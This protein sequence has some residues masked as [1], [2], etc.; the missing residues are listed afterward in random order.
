MP[1]EA[2]DIPTIWVSSR[3][4]DL[5][6]DQMR[7]VTCPGSPAAWRTDVL[8]ALPAMALRSH[9]PLC[10]GSLPPG[11]VVDAPLLSSSRAN[12]VPSPEPGHWR[13]ASR[14]RPATPGPDPGKDSPRRRATLHSTACVHSIQIPRAAFTRS[15]SAEIPPDLPSPSRQMRR[16]RENP[17]RRS[18]PFP[19]LPEKTVSRP[20]GFAPAPPYEVVAGFIRCGEWREFDA[21]RARHRLQSIAPALSRAVEAGICKCILGTHTEISRLDWPFS[22]GV[23]AFPRCRVS[24]VSSQCRSLCC[25]RLPPRHCCRLYTL[26]NMLP[27][28]H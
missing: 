27:P 1:L 18:Y 3:Q 13:P 11:P 25:G 22:I 19:P 20:K 15:Q 8:R 2:L 6:W 14:S 16:A 10:T 9:T 12:A 4:T 7:C 23:S 21:G 28:D 5:R 26:M 24:P 17:F